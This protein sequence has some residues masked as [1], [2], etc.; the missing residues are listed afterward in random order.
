[1]A[2]ELNNRTK[3]LAG[4]VALAAVGAGAWFFFLEEFIN[5]PPPK[6]AAAQ[7]APAAKQGDA[8]KPAEAAPAQAAAPGAKPIPSNPDRLIAEVIEAAGVKAQ[9]QNYSRSAA[10]RQKAGD[11]RELADLSARAFDADAMTAEVAVSLKAGFDADRLSRFLEILRQPPAA[12]IA[13]LSAGPTAEEYAPL[14]EGL[15]KNPPSAARQKLIVSI[16][17]ITQTSEIGVPL[18]SLEAREMADA[19][20]DTMQKSGKRAPK[21]MKQKAAAQNEAAQGAMRATIRSLMHATYRDAS[22]QEL[23]GYVKLMDTDT[24]RW[25]MGL[26][27]SARRAAI[28]Q[29][30]RN[31]AQGMAQA[32]LR[33]QVVAEAPAQR[34]AA[35]AAEEPKAA[36]KA[37][38]APAAAPVAA[39]GYQRPA[40][41]RDAYA[42]YNDVISATVM[43]DR[44][45]LKELLDDGKNPNARQSDGIT[46]LMIAASNGDADIAAM[47]LAKGA[48][49]NLRAGNRSALSIAKARGSAG[50]PMVQLLERGGAKN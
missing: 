17:E 33:K 4:V 43:R 27:A 44:A 12:R 42:R 16:D 10:A 6:P 29:R 14:L 21:E 5:E 31:F 11:A 36:E 9:L 26:L 34:P 25:G 40:N 48:D 49:P 38:A 20:L 3:I 22:D 7:V 1:M 19:M 28:E 15:R 24:G 45:A 8:A 46:P 23:A 37:P 32:A 18:A 41:I 47:L 2:I 30:T 39:P 50:A 35:A 13:A